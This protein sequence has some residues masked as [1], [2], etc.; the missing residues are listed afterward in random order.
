MPYSWPKDCGGGFDVG[1]DSLRRRAGG[2]RHSP[3]LFLWLNVVA[4]YGTELDFECS[5]DPRTFPNRQTGAEET[6]YRALGRVTGFLVTRCVLLLQAGVC[7]IR[8]DVRR[9]SYRAGCKA[10]QWDAEAAL[11]DKE[12]AAAERTP[13]REASIGIRW[14]GDRLPTVPDP[15]P[16]VVLPEVDPLDHYSQR[17][18]RQP[19]RFR[20]AVAELFGAEESI[21][22]QSAQTLAPSTGPVESTFKRD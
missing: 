17:E 13:D 3:D 4:Q 7:G 1:K 15:A 2:H 16:E 9:A 6:P 12:Y 22:H 20:L 5:T 8:D 19:P 18:N 21:V 10:G 11:D 14:P